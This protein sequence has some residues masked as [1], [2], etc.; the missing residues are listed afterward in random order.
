MNINKYIDHTLLKADS[1]KDQIDQLLQEAKEFDFASVCVNPSWVS[2]CAKELTGT[3]VKVCTVVGFPLGATTSETKSFETKNAI[4]NGA[5]EIDM[6]INIGAL[7]QGDFE[8][9]EKDIKA[10]VDASGDKL[11]KVIIEACLLT[12]EQKVKACT[13]VV[14]AG[15]DFVKTSTGF[16]TGGAT[17]SD[18]K[19]M[20]Q[21][22]GPDIGVKAAGGARSLEDALAFIEAGATRIGTSSGVKII[23]G[24]IANGGY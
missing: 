24:E 9:V 1:V 23:N 5:D 12:D 11:V 17:V 22:V 13:L 6:V 4:A 15:A 20:R 16:S 2:Y 3:D 10:V 21:T 18:V 8:T 19:L 14:N 7:K